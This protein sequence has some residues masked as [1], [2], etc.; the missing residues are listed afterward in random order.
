MMKALTIPKTVKEELNIQ[1]ENIGD[2]YLISNT[3]TVP[4]KADEAISS[5]PLSDEEEVALTKAL[6]SEG[7]YH[8]IPS[9]FKTLVYLKKM[10][11]EFSIV[12]R[13][14]NAQDLQHVIAEFN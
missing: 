8:L 3:P 11:K 7:K 9:F 14:Y 6:L 12:F 10:K 1:D 2:N 4:L 13:N 5:T